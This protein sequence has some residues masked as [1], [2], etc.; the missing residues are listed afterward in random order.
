MSI[1]REIRSGLDT[2]MPDFR[3][4]LYWQ[5][6]L[7]T[8]STG[9]ATVSF[10]TGDTGNP[11]DVWV[12]GLS[13]DG[14]TGTAIVPL[15]IRESLSS[16]SGF[17]RIDTVRG[18]DQTDYRRYGL[19]SGFIGEAETGKALTN[20]QI[21]CIRP[22]FHVCTN[23]EEEFLFPEKLLHEGDS[24]AISCVGYIDKLI[25][26]KDFVNGKVAIVLSEALF[27]L[28]KLFGLEPDELQ[29]NGTGNV[30]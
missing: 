18:Q 8:D 26:R 10:Y 13:L 28:Y 4:T 19:L 2:S 7:I 17:S 15:N 14:T 6:D 24:L 25:T 16:S 20:A 27:E 3:R 30:Q 11:A 23:N 29:S 21:T 5:P 9:Q 22:Y 1:C 12:Q